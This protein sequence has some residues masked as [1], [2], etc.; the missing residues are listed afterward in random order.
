MVYDV[1]LGVR[2]QASIE[3]EQPCSFPG[4]MEAGLC[5]NC[6]NQGQTEPSIQPL[7]KSV[8]KSKSGLSCC[9]HAITKPEQ[10]PAV[11]V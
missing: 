2:S 8:L 9:L 6:A 3:F 10:K 4:K 11:L 1:Y 7:Y 5:K